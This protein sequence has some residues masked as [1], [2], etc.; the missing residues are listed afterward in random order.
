APMML[1][2]HMAELATASTQAEAANDR[3]V[4]SHPFRFDSVQTQQIPARQKLIGKQMQTETPVRVIKPLGRAAAIDLAGAA[5]DRRAVGADH[6]ETEHRGT[7]IRRIDVDLCQHRLTFPEKGRRLAL[8]AIDAGAT[9]AVL[10]AAV[11]GVDV[12]RPARLLA[13]MERQVVLGHVEHIAIGL[14]PAVLEP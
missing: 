8:H 3:I 5:V 1:Q 7:P 9:D 6:T 2:P 13:L 14:D 10:A 12:A 4:E 11:A